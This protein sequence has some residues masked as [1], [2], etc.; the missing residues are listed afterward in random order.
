[1]SAKHSRKGARNP[2]PAPAAPA[3]ASGLDLSSGAAAVPAPTFT[4]WIDSN[5]PRKRTFA[6]VALVAVWLYVAA[7]WLLA[8]DQTFDWGIFGPKIPPSP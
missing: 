6:K 8:L 3:T 5:D 1:M 2:A 4:P 7:L